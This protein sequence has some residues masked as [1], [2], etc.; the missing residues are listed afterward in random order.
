M[1]GCEQGLTTEQEWLAEN[2]TNSLTEE[3]V[4][5]LLW[6]RL[7]DLPQAV[8]SRRSQNYTDQSVAWK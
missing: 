3:N 1:G 5:T 2:S 4:E 7:M 8:T 6:L